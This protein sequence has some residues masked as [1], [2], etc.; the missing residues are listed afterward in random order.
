MNRRIA[1]LA[2]V[3]LLATA[4][5]VVAQQQSFLYPA[6]FRTNVYLHDDAVTPLHVR[7]SNTVTEAQVGVM[8]TNAVSGSTN[9]I[10]AGITNTASFSLAEA[11]TN[12]YYVGNAG[13][14]N[15]N[16]RY[17]YEQ[18]R[19]SKHAY[20]NEVGWHL[21]WTLTH[22][23]LRDSGFAL[24]YVSYD[25][26]DTPDKATNWTSADQ[27]GLPPVP[28]VYKN[29]PYTPQGIHASRVEGLVAAASAVVSNVAFVGSYPVFKLDL[30]SENWTD[31]ALKCAN[32][33][34]SS[35]N[36]LYYYL[37][38]VDAASQPTA[39]ETNCWVYYTDD[40]S[41]NPRVWL[42]K[43]VNGSI[44]AQ[45]LDV[46]SAVGT[47]YVMPSLSTLPHGKEYMVWSWARHDALGYE[48]NYDG[49]KIRWQPIQPEYWTTQR[50][51]I[52]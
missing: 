26:V 29:T 31:F 41:D 40:Y 46:H 6:Y 18:E 23:D 11:D 34:W 47:V 52:P 20:T 5:A 16:K 38:Y 21:A 10:I 2:V 15:A 12:V 44:A 42:R 43:D 19:Y 45:L 37:S 4:H 22:W 33:N 50:T 7:L 35:G 48:M 14:T 27:Y 49:T 8:I 25:A 9:A 24:R 1:K 17:T 13:L 30:G 28:V 36:S 51:T 39:E 32:D 3:A